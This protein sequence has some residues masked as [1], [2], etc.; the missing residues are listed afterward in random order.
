MSDMVVRGYGI[1]GAAEYLVAVVKRRF[2]GL[3]FLFP[4]LF[5][6]RDPH[7]QCWCGS[8]AVAVRS[9]A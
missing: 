7:W 1:D 4:H 6:C 8:R 3:C 9:V 2:D 5:P